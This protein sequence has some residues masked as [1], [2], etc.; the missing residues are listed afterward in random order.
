MKIS[1]NKSSIF[2]PIIYHLASFCRMG[3]RVI[4]PLLPHDDEHGFRISLRET[5]L[6]IDA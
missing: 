6:S 2:F 1:L 4:A 3:K 5:F